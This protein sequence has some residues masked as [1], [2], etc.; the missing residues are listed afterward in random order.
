M[1]AGK[2]TLTAVKWHHWGRS[3]ATATGNSIV[4]RCAKACNT[5]PFVRSS[6]RLTVSKPGTF[7]GRRVYTCFRLTAS[8]GRKA[9]GCLHKT[10]GAWRFM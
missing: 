10:A 9:S 6:M 8:D 3:T 4:S 1:P 5:G 7:A 2:W